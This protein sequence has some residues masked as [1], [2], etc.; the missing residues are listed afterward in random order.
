MFCNSINISIISVFARNYV[1]INLE[2]TYVPYQH[3]N[4]LPS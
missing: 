3:H 2:R 1:L 4:N